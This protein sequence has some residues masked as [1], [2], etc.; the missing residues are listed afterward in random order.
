MEITKESIEALKKEIDA[1]L[2]S[3][4]KLD[5]LG[6]GSDILCKNKEII[7]TLLVGVAT[8]WLGKGGA[9]LVKLGLDDWFSKHCE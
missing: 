9:F 7:T 5:A 1:D 3:Q 8:A 6:A 2:A 4:T